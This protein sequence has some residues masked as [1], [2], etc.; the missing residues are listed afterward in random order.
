MRWGRPLT[1]YNKITAE[2]VSSFQIFLFGGGRDSN[3]SRF[4]GVSEARTQRRN[5]ERSRRAGIYGG[6]WSLERTA[7]QIKFPANREFYREIWRF[8]LSF[9]DGIARILHDSLRLTRSGGLFHVKKTGKFFEITGNLNSLLR[10][11]AAKICKFPCDLV[12]KN[13]SNCYYINGDFFKS[14]LH[15][16]RLL[17]TPGT[18]LSLSSDSV[19]SN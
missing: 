12:A 2:F 10:F 4:A 15:E 14:G 16:R 11:R 9:T 3:L 19:R 5:P 13:V 18:L 1:L 7:L 6:G 17:L 8:L